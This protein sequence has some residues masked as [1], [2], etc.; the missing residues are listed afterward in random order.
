MDNETQPLYDN[1][2][3]IGKQNDF[4]F[5]ALAYMGNATHH[6][7]WANTVLEHEEKVPKELKAE[8]LQTTAKIHELQDRLRE[9]R[10]QCKPKEFN[11]FINGREQ[12][13]ITTKD[14]GAF[15]EENYPGVEYE[16]D[17]KERILRMSISLQKA[18]EIANMD[19][20]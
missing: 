15:V 12:G 16:V 13:S 9:L 10:N 7:S 14:V 6:M 1:F 2:K 19:N 4:I 17:E 8:M 18:L 11:V 5:Q 3:R 20:R